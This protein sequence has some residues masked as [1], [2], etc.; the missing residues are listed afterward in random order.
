MGSFFFSLK[1]KETV[2]YHCITGI[3][4]TKNASRAKRGERRILRE[5]QNEREARDDGGG[6]ND[7][8]SSLDS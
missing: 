3:A 5:A 7:A 2:L 6:K 1:R 4:C 8:F